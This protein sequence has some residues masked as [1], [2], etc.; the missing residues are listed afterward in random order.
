MIGVNDENQIVGTTLNNNKRSVLQDVLNDINP[1]VPVVTYN[2]DIDDNEVWVIEV[3]SGQ[4]KPYTFGGAIFIRQGPN[5]QKITSVEQMRD[6]FQLSNRIYF[7]EAPCP[8]FNPEMDIEGVFFDE[9]RIKAGLSPTVNK[10]Q[11][12]QNLKLLHQDG[13][14]KNGAVLFFGK[15]P[16]HFFEKAVI[17]CVAFDGF[18]KTFIIDDKVY[19]GPLMWQY[20]QA[21]QW[22]RGKLNIRYI[23]EGAGPRKESWEIPESVL[24]EAI[25]NALTHRDYYEKGARTTVEV[26]KD[27][28][29][30]RNPGGLV[31]VISEK[32]FGTK[33]HSRNPLLFGLFERIDMVEQIGSGISRMRNDMKEAKLPQ[34]AFM[35]QGTFA[36]ILQRSP[37]ANEDTTPKTTSKTTSKTTQVLKQKPKEKIVELIYLNNE[38][39]LTEM[40]NILGIT[41]EGVKYH[42]NSLKKNGIVDR[43]GPT[44]G[45]K[46]IILKKTDHLS[47]T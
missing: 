13:S 6:F 25:I 4:Q 29:E 21:M 20:M 16:E 19:T 39:T 33:S 11:I 5:T 8:E 46:W 30:I 28:V 38:I 3:P 23:I 27:R 47:S 1:Y 42:M 22:L 40:A 26:F 7:D 31:S 15:T 45:G 14:M 9:F 2:V 17:R 24:K 36:V 10:A 18:D 43:K 41:V 32:D 44:H 37:K 12:I 34:P 35:T